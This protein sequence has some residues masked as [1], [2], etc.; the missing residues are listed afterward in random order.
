[1]NELS[2]WPACRLAETLGA[3]EGA[4]GD[5]NEDSSDSQPLKKDVGMVR[6]LLLAVASKSGRECVSILLA[7]PT[8][9]CEMFKFQSLHSR[10]LV[11]VTSEGVSQELD[12]HL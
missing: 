8:S 5:Y 10:K 4:G 2:P 6:P 1:M 3:D 7:G 9:C 12:Q 11:L